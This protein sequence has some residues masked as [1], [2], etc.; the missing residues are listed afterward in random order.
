MASNQSTV[1][2][3]VDQMSGAGNVSAK[4]MFGE[5]S[6]YCGEKLVAL[7]CDNKLF[8]KPTA[9]GRAY[10]GDVD[11]APPYTGAKLCFLI[12]G[13]RW[14]DREWLSRLVRITAENCQCQ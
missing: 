2:F 9:G 13:E 3:I 7:V 11:E 12:S 14:E 1:D 8:I 10:I 5:Y 6:I 4:K